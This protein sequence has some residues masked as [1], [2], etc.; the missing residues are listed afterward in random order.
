MTIGYL[1]SKE[2]THFTCQE[3]IKN[4]SYEK[5]KEYLYKQRRLRDSFKEY[6]FA[7]K[8]CFMA[9]KRNRHQILVAYM[10]SKINDE[11]WRHRYQSLFED[12]QEG[13]ER[14]NLIN[15]FYK[16]LFSLESYDIEARKKFLSA[17]THKYMTI[18]MHSYV[19]AEVLRPITSL[20]LELLKN[21]PEY[22]KQA[23][24]SIEDLAL[25]FELDLR[26]SVLMAEANVYRMID[27]R[28]ASVE[29]KLFSL[30]AKAHSDRAQNYFGTMV[31]DFSD[32]RDALNR[33]LV[34]KAK[35]ISD[36]YTYEHFWAVK[37]YIEDSG[38]Q[39][40][41]H[42]NG[43]TLVANILFAMRH[44]FA[45]E[46]ISVDL[47]CLDNLVKKEIQIEEFVLLKIIYIIIE[48][49]LQSGASMISVRIGH[50]LKDIVIKVSNNGEP[51]TELER[52]HC[53]DRFFSGNCK[54]GLGL[55]IARQETLRFNGTI[56]VDNE[57]TFKVSFPRYIKT[58]N[59]E[60]KK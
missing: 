46:P 42:G 11:L 54:Q 47:S 40:S 37:E 17:F 3:A 58:K 60:D 41:S 33:G 49:A 51:M 25:F 10:V 20:M 2:N 13:G 30:S 39:Y 43:R 22:E 24:T 38:R 14:F 35:R 50:E 9:V 53:F 55:F 27:I 15:E 56:E 48:N 36:R 59:T 32:I 5:I 45:G 57:G 31:E 29:N 28:R 19:V 12:L 6:K 7:L 44:L 1:D 52:T 4:A 8:R 16:H 21:R 34:D 26:L 23:D 18:N